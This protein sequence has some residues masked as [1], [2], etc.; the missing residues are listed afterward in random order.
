MESFNEA[1][2]LWM[3]CGCDDMGNVEEMGKVVPKGGNELGST[4]R[5]NCMGK[6]KMGNPG[7]TEGIST[8]SGRG[9]RKRNG[10]NPAGG[11]VNDGEDVGVA[12]GRRERSHK[13]RMG[14]TAGRN[15]NLG[16]RR[17]NVG[18]G[19]GGLAGKTLPSPEV[20]VPG[21]PLP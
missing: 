16:W 15:G 21:H 17:R 9:G 11:L 3:E 4:I 2:G 13:V 14:K 5:G 19:F 1:I 6:A 18:V 12:L 10:L 7:G 20:D 8:D